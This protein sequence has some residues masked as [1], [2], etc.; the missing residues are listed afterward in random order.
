M[1]ENYKKIWDANQKAFEKGY[2]NFEEYLE[3]QVYLINAWAYAMETQV[4]RLEAKVYD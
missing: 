1:I 4:E 3:S 2:T